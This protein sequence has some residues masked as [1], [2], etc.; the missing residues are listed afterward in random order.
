MTEHQLLCAYLD[1]LPDEWDTTYHQACCHAAAAFLSNLKQAATTGR[2]S[3]KRHDY[4][5]KWFRDAMRVQ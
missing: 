2:V 5:R 1:S 4:W 3:W